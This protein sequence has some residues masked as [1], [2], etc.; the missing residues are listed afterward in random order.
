MRTRQ[1]FVSLATAL[2]A[3]TAHSAA[4]A[5]LTL[6]WDPNAETDIAGYVVKY[7]EQPHDYHVAVDVGLATTLKLDG[8]TAGTKYYFTVVAYGTDGSSSVVATELPALVSGAPQ[9]VTGGA[10][11]AVALDAD[12]RLA[13]PL[14]QWSTVAGA[15]AYLLRVGSTSGGG[16]VADRPLA[17]SSF[18]LPALPFDR[19][20]YARIFTKQS[21]LWSYDEVAFRMPKQGSAARMIAPLD[22]QVAVTSAQTFRWDAIAQAQSYTFQIGTRADLA[23]VVN[24][25]ETM[26]TWWTTPALPAD[27]RLYAR[28]STKIAGNWYSQTIEFASA[29]TSVLVYPYAGAS[30]TSA[31]ETFQWTGITDAQAY[32]LDVGT[33]P[34]G[35][36]IVESGDTKATTF[37]VTGLRPGQTLYARVATRIKGVWQVD[38]VTFTTAFSARVTRPAAGDGSDLGRGL[39]WTRI[40]GAE[41]YNLRL[42]STAGGDDL[43]NSGDVLATD[44]ETPALPAGIEIFARLATT[45][46]GEVRQRD[47]SFTLAGAA[48]KVSASGTP[49][50]ANSSLGQLLTWTAISNAEAYALYVGTQPGA[51]DLVNSGDV[52]GTSYLATNLPAGRTLYVSLW[53]KA[54]GV[55]NGTAATLTTK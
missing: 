43:L 33:T 3:L 28:V 30:D 14:L 21:G 51:K 24:S 35:S 44:V 29:P 1:L 50:A 49:E 23:D 55:W 34:G 53:T 27:T 46:G 20:Y 11:F 26:R 38:A 32:R 12:G 25:G 36:D 17:T 37:P 8:L 6:A 45:H 47:T 41:S 2:V 16:D 13:T 42:G 7:G 10:Q 22:G 5:G 4:A 40:I 15:E 48:L 31:S 39:A 19:T 9:P 54:N 18:A 52:Q